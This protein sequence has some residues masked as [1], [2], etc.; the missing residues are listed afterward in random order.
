MDFKADSRTVGYYFNIK[1]FNRA[2]FAKILTDAIRCQGRPIC[3]DKGYVFFRLIYTGNYEKGRII[4]KEKS[5]V[6]Y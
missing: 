5:K 6:F 3:C 2:S 1:G 4:F